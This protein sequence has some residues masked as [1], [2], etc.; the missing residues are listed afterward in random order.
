M[1]ENAC[2][3][4]RLLNRLIEDEL[5]VAEVMDLTFPNGTVD[6]DT[7]RDFYGGTPLKGRMGD[8]ADQAERCETVA[9]MFVDKKGYQMAQEFI[10]K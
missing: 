5:C 4:F 2:K 7:L 1:E 3:K 6:F 8:M 10:N 9:E